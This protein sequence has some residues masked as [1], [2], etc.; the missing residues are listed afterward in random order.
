MGNVKDKK[1]SSLDIEMM[2]NVE[3]LQAFRAV[4]PHFTERK[5][6]MKS[7]NCSYP[8][9]PMLEVRQAMLQAKTSYDSIRGIQERLNQA[10]NDLIKG[11]S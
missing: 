4:H 5:P 11:S 3:K 9:T 6:T 1:D 8:S 10:Y 7:H 2:E